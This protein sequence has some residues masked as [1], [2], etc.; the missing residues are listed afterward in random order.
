MPAA[1][2]PEKPLVDNFVSNQVETEPT[3]RSGQQ[4]SPA[5]NGQFLT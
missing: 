1:E 4:E 2:I 3:A 5:E